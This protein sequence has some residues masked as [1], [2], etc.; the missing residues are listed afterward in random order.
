M[1]N[2]FD[3][4]HFIARGTKRRDGNYCKITCLPTTKHYRVGFSSAVSAVVNDK[5]LTHIQLHVERYTSSVFVVFL[6]SNDNVD[7]RVAHEQSGQVRVNNVDLVLYLTKKLGLEGDVN[8][9]TLELS[10]DLANDDNYATFR[11]NFPNN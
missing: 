3:V 6:K 1:A 7:A 10:P 5:G 9:Y 11:I 4:L 8:G 2:D